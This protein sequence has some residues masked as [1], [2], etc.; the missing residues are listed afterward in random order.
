[1]KASMSG[2]SRAEIDEEWSIGDYVLSG[3]ELPALVV[4]DAIGGC[5]PECW[6]ARSRLC[7]SPSPAI[8]W[9]GRITHGRR[10]STVAQFPAVLSS[11]DHAAIE[12]WRLRQALGR[13]W[14]AAAGVARAARNE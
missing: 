1:M 6:G 9:T 10:R 8:W 3:G 5:C 12:R 14:L 2:S 11:G 13:T 7:R 4:I